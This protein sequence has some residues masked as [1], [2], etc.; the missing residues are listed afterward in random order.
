LGV[1]IG[2]SQQG[3]GGDPIWAAESGKV[4]KA[5]TGY[6]GGY[7]NVV[8]IDHQNGYSTRYAHMKKVLV[9]TGQTI[10]RGQIIGLMGNTGRS[11]GAH[12]HFEVQYKG[13]PVDPMTFFK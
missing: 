10:E 9:R 5:A 3:I 12:L 11:D 6:N 4:T 1:D 8:Y 7:G 13:K 2:A